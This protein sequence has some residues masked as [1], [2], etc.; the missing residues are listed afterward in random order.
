MVLLTGVQLVILHLRMMLDSKLF[1]LLF[2]GLLLQDSFWHLRTCFG[3]SS[4]HS[5]CGKISPSWLWQRT[6]RCWNPL[7]H[8]ASH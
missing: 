6:W 7:P 3:C 4:L 2:L 5:L 8:V 1:S